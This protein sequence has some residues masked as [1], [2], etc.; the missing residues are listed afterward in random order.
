[1]H[2]RFLLVHTNLRFILQRRHWKKKDPL[3][4]LEHLL[5][6]TMSS[7]L[8]KLTKD[9]C[10]FSLESSISIIYKLKNQVF[11]DFI[12]LTLNFSCL[13]RRV[14]HQSGAIENGATTTSVKSTNTIDTNSINS[15][16]KNV[17]EGEN[18]NIEVIDFYELMEVTDEFE[19]KISNK[20][21]N[22]KI[23]DND[24]AT[25]T[26]QSIEKVEC[27]NKASSQYIDSGEVE[28][29]AQYFRE[30]INQVSNEY[31]E[32]TDSQYS[33]RHKCN[34]YEITDTLR[35]IHK[36]GNIKKTSSPNVGFTEVNN[37]STKYANPNLQNKTSSRNVGSIEVNNFSTKYADLNL[38]N[39]TSSQNVGYTEVNNF[40]RKYVNPNLYNKI[41]IQ[42]VGST[43]VNNFSTK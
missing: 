35:S 26:I 33:N 17:D 2:I 20:N 42:N 23:S 16:S 14:K 31:K 22:S 21:T 43:K 11:I 4:L 24:D 9:I 19:V 38:Q 15:R 34:N 8:I 13:H 27:T 12:T 5:C 40:S 37:F 36:I 30:S 25:S 28:N 1:M 3:L 41:S 39:K 29:V 6:V 7:F 32:N 18:E 10:N